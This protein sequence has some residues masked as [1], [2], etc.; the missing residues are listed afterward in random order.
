MSIAFTLKKVIS[1]LIM[2]LSIGLIFALVGLYYL[3]KNSYKKA[4]IFLTFSVVW[5]ALI[6]YSP[7]SNQLLTPLETK[8]T[9]LENIPKDVKHILLLGG[10]LEN[11]GWEA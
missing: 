1:G 4:K 5:I 2:P 3:Y 7:I 8:Y 10:D 11:R 9:K 6:S